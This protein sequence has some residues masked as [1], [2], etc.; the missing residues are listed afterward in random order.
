M[1]YFMLDRVIAFTSGKR[2][3]AI[4]N[5]TLA[6]NILHD[7]HPD[8][9]IL[10]SALV[11]EAMSQLGAFLIE[12]SANRP[13]YIRRA[14]LIQ[15]DQAEFI[16]SAEPGDQLVLHVYMEEQMEDNAKISARVNRS[17]EKMAGA[18]MRFILQT[19]DSEKIHEQKRYV[20]KLWTKQLEPRPPIL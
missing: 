18:K 7:H 3:S 6:E 13:D 19:I 14:Q 9:P 8:Q 15:I 4:K 2:A 1:R 11:I 16:A 5:V 10:P 12:M 17:G 20:Y